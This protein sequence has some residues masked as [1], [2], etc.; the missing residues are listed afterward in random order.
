M[1]HLLRTRNLMVPRIGKALAS[2]NMEMG[3]K[4]DG[5]DKTTGETGQKMSES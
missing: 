3:W 1:T 4:W 2:P 5:D